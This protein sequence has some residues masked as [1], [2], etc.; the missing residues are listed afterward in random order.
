M[1]EI[2][3]HLLGHVLVF[4]DESNAIFQFHNVSNRGKKPDFQRFYKG[5]EKK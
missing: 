1:Q 5:K 3:K 4:H 2:S